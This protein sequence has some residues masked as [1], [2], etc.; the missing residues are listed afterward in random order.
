MIADALSPDWQATNV[1]VEI[2]ERGLSISDQESVVFEAKRSDI[3][4]CERLGPDAIR[5]VTFVKRPIVER[6]WCGCRRKVV[7]RR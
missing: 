3:L 1:K 2:S 5:V 7:H 6:S 4:N